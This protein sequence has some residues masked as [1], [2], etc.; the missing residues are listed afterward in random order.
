MIEGIKAV[1]FDLDGTF[2]K[3]HVDYSKLRDA[4]REVLA[5]R[6]IPFDEVYRET[7]IKRPRYPVLRWLEA[8]GREDEFQAVSDEIDAA[9]TRVEIEFVDEA[10]PFPGSKE[11]VAELRS[12]GLKTGILT[13]GSLEYAESALRHTDTRD[14]FDVVMGRDFSSYDNAKPSPVAMLE[15][16]EQLGVKPSE[17]LYIGDN[18][19]DYMSAHGAEAMFAGVLTGS[20][21]RELWEST[22]PSIIILEKAGDCARLFRSRGHSPEA[23]P[24]PCRRCSGTR[25]RAWTLRRCSIPC[26]SSPA[27]R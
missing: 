3:T 26:R 24:A 4:D 13:R 10:V 5:A 25:S 2:L 27:G 12:L 15:F 18:L 6:G 21:K 9:F 1:G 20:G 19:T 16:A 23:C 14:G 7:F 17:I 8:H 22:D 11:C